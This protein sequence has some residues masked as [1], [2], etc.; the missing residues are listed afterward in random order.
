MCLTITPVHKMHT[1]THIHSR[2]WYT[3]RS[4]LLQLPRPSRNRSSRTSPQNPS[5]RPIPC[6][7][8]SSPTPCPSRSPRRRRSSAG[9]DGSPKKEGR[10]QTTLSSPSPRIRR[11]RG[12]WAPRTGPGT[13]RQP[14]RASF[15]ARAGNA[16]FPRRSTWRPLLRRPRKWSLCRRTLSR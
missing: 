8:L 15:R 13:F 7:R 1:L 14:R 12:C 4:P 10:R 5:S 9:R 3:P 6:S 2:W 11:P 16:G